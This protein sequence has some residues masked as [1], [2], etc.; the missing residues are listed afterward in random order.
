VT[1]EPEEALDILLT[2]C[3]DA[4][5]FPPYAEIE[6]FL[7]SRNG[8]D[9]RATER[10]IIAAALEGAPALLLKSETMDWHR[11]V[12]AIIDAQTGAAEVNGNGKPAGERSLRGIVGGPALATETSSD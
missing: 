12:A 6:H 3:E 10:A 9:L 11:R 8:S 1:L 7:H 5:G 4:Y 2:N